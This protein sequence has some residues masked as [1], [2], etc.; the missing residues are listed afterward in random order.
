MRRLGP[1]NMVVWCRGEGPPGMDSGSVQSLLRRICPSC[2]PK[3]SL[4]A[5]PSMASLH[6]RPLI[7]RALCVAFLLMKSTEASIK[8]ACITFPIL[9]VL[10]H[11][12]FKS[13]HLCVDWQPSP[14]EVR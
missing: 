5:L 8:Q 10:H 11:T 13:T 3:V 6:A 7:A 12:G 9:A 1:D 4:P 14:L 2:L